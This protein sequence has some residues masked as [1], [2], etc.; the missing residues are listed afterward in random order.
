MQGHLNR[1]RQKRASSIPW[2]PKWLEL[3]LALLD[4]PRQS[5]PPMES[6]GT[7][8]SP[9]DS[10]LAQQLPEKSPRAVQSLVKSPGALQL[11][12]ESPSALLSPVKTSREVASM[13]LV[14]KESAPAGS[15]DLIP[16]HQPLDKQV[17]T[18]AL[19]APLCLAYTGHIFSWQQSCSMEWN[20]QHQKH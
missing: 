14:H 19:S 1:A 15:A 6:T 2:T 3:E 9:K 17:C 11:L 12:A 18:A 4:N 20:P 16:A 13:L 7:V 5:V 10:C 8:E